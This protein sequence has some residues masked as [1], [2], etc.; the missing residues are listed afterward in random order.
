MYPRSIFLEISDINA[1]IYKCLDRAITHIDF[2]DDFPNNT[3]SYG[4]FTIS[5]YTPLFFATS[6]EIQRY[7]YNFKFVDF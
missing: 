7:H 2:L 6:Q 3:L 5:D 1:P 4:N